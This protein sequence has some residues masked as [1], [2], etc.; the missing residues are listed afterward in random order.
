MASSLPAS[1]LSTPTR[2]FSL[3]LCRSRESRFLAFVPKAQRLD[4][5]AQFWCP[6]FGSW[7]CYVQSDTS[8]D[9]R[10]LWY[11]IVLIS[12]IISS[13]YD[14]DLLHQRTIEK[15][16]KRST[17]TWHSFEHRNSLPG[18]RRRFKP[19]G[20]SSSNSQ[21]NV[22]QRI[23]LSGWQSTCP[24]LF[25]VTKLSVPLVLLKNGIITIP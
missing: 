19:F 21:R 2:E 12:V 22:G 11:V 3:S 16:L 9:E 20:L 17:S 7:N 5:C 24:G 10:R 1:F 8:F 14:F 4:Q 6:T 23:M 13:I 18:T 15:S 25:L